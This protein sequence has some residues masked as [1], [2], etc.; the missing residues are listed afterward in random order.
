MQH[1]KQR[2][3]RF[4]PCHW[5]Q[6]QGGGG[7]GCSPC[8][9]RICSLTPSKVPTAVP[10]VLLECM[11]T[12]EQVLF[13]GCRTKEGCAGLPRLEDSIGF[14]SRACSC[15]CPNPRLIYPSLPPAPPKATLLHGCAIYWRWLS[16]V[17]LS[18]ADP[19][20]VFG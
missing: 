19:A 8:I 4:W 20:S 1:K 10:M 7:E 5:L 18:G 16:N 2:P 15:F 14:G 6:N 13:K 17:P 12:F 3:R 11:P 9:R